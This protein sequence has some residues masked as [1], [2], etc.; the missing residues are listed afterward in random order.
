MNALKKYLKKELRRALCSAA[1]TLEN[2]GYSYNGGD[3]WKPPL[4][5]PPNFS[6]IDYWRIRAEVME[7]AIKD[8]MCCTVC[9][10]H[11]EKG[12]GD[13]KPCKNYEFDH[14]RYKNKES[15]NEQ[16]QD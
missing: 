12:C 1:K 6:L 9:I 7:Q 14:A 4:G 8:N 13:V 10:N 15:E 11:R 2:L 16:D 3:L 5:K